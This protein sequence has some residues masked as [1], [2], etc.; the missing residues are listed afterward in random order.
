LFKYLIALVEIPELTHLKFTLNYNSTAIYK[1]QPILLDT[2]VF[3]QLVRHG[4]IITEMLA[5]SIQM[6]K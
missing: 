4:I 2:K 5:F 3:I 1:K 6:N